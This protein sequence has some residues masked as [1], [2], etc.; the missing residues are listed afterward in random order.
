MLSQASI[1]LCLFVFVSS[2]SA[3][4]VNNL[5]AEA[6]AA[7]NIILNLSLPR[8]TPAPDNHELRRRQE[9]QRTLLVG[10]DAT[11]GYIGGNATQP[12]GC[13]AS[14]TCAFATPTIGVLDSTTTTA[15]GSVLCC[16]SASGCPTKPGPTSCV[17]KHRF[18][19]KTACTGSCLEDERVLKCTSGIYLFCNTISFP[20]P[21]LSAF[22]CNYISTY[23]PILA[24]TTIS[25]QGGREFTPTI[26]ALPSPTSSS[27]LS[28][29][30]SPSTSAGGS[31]E[32][33]GSSPSLSAAASNGGK[34]KSNKGAIIGGVIGGVAGLALLIAAVFFVLRWRKMKRELGPVIGDEFTTKEDVDAQ[35]AAAGDGKTASAA[36]GSSEEVGKVE[37]EKPVVEGK[38]VVA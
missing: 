18:D 29:S 8:P 23:S 7:S 36:S 24:Q 14:S 1:P 11:C 12:W 4:A 16:D 25:G 9:A 28:S 19:I 33:A 31:V 6:T 35:A 3:L 34:K 26:Q 17:D 20:T 2:A 21:S 15:P 22:F 37:E 30:T 10:P 38:K 27:S 13:T 32:S 5:P